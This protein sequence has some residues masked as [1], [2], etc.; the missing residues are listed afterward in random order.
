MSAPVSQWRDDS[1]APMMVEG[2]NKT[3]AWDFASVRPIARRIAVDAARRAGMSLEEWLDEAIVDRAVSARPQEGSADVNSQGSDQRHDPF[4][5]GE[6]LNRRDLRST[7]GIE[8]ACVRDAP[9][10]L[11]SAV[12]RFEERMAR[13]EERTARVFETIAHI[14]DQTDRNL[15][16]WGPFIASGRSA[17]AEK[18]N[19]CLATQPFEASVADVEAGREQRSVAHRN[20]DQRMEEIVR[21]IGASHQSPDELKTSP[22]HGAERPRLDLNAAV[23]QIALRRRALDAREA[24]SGS[25]STENGPSP[26]ARQDPGGDV[27]GEPGDGMPHSA[28][29]VDAPPRALVRS[30]LGTAGAAS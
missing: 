6:P 17:K 19:L 14:L 30:S 10:F 26:S 23:S 8:E 15:D 28:N 13:G 29:S 4:S 22:N 7:L 3:T 1:Q 27:V 5:H 12:A 25:V 11:E 18:P 9:N 16:R 2:M 21:R 24:S 20:L